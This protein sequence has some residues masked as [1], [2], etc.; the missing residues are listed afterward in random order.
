MIEKKVEYKPLSVKSLLTSIKNISEL[1]VDLA[2]SAVL[3]NDA[4]LRE[5]VLELEEYV[6][7]MT[8]LLFMSASFAVRDKEDAER[9]AG[10]M[11]LAMAANRISDAAG[12]IASTIVRGEGL[13]ILAQA[14]SKTEERIMRVTVSKNSSLTNKRIDSLR[15][16]LG[17]DVIA[18]RRRGKLLI[19]PKES[20]KLVAG[21][22]VVVRGTDKSLQEFKRIAEE[23]IDEK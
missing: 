22:V 14:F 2:Y 16:Q 12:D 15:G 1:T 11:K 6:D 9:M 13:K 17:I 20:T 23:N 3:F 4:E 7:Y 10:I 8:Y 19:N 18:V 5:E 21:D